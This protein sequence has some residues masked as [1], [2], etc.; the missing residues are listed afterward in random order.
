MVGALVPCRP[1]C[2]SRPV[3]TFRGFSDRALDFYAALATD[4]SRSFWG[5]HREVFESEVRDPMRALVEALE[6]EFGQCTVFRPHRDTRFSRDKSP[7]KTHQGAFAGIAPGI[8]YY[9]QI[10]ATGLLAGGGFLSHGS[11]QVTRYR[12]AVDEQSTG[13]QLAEIVAVLQG[14]GFAIEGEQLKTRPRGY[15][16]DHPRLD[17]LRRKSLMAVKTFGA[18]GWLDSP[19]ALDEV[20]ATWRQ[21][22]P[23][24]SWIAANVGPTEAERTR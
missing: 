11:D 4:N 14:S 21:V 12:D 5:E 3:A 10:D 6:P 24:S 18:P 16:A 22:T 19:K 15:A 8:G 2:E 17:L 23:L 20:R 7:Y 1:S 13:P 9:V